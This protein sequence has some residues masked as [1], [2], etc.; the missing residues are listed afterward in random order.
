M[1]A[2]AKY[3]KNIGISAN[4]DAA[5]TLRDINN[6]ICAGGARGRLF[7]KRY[8]ESDSPLYGMLRRAAAEL[9]EL[10]AQMEYKGKGADLK[11]ISALQEMLAQRVNF[12]T[13]NNIYNNQVNILEAAH[14]DLLREA[15]PNQGLETS[16]GIQVTAAGGVGAGVDGGAKAV[17]KLEGSAQYRNVDAIVYDDDL[18]LKVQ[19]SDVWQLKFAAKADADGPIDFR[20][21]GAEAAIAGEV[22]RQL[23]TK[24]DRPR[25]AFTAF[26]SNQREAYVHSSPIHF[27]NHQPDWELIAEEEHKDI[28]RATDWAIPNLGRSAIERLRALPASTVD[29]L[30]VPSRPFNDLQLLK[31]QAGASTHMLHD[32]LGRLKDEALNKYTKHFESNILDQPSRVYRGHHDQVRDVTSARGQVEVKGNIGVF[33]KNVNDGETHK[34]GIGA[35]CKLSGHITRTTRDATL[36]MPPHESIQKLGEHYDGGAGAA[37]ED[38]LNKNRDFRAYAQRSADRANGVSGLAADLSSFRELSCQMQAA[39]A[40]LMNNKSMENPV[41]KG[42]AWKSF[43]DAHGRLQETFLF[44]PSSLPAD[45][46]KEP[47]LVKLCYKQFGK[48]W[49]ALSTGMAAMKHGQSGAGNQADAHELKALAADIKEVGVQGV[50]PL[51][52]YAYSDMLL[53]N[54]SYK[55]WDK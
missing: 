1:D 33:N 24:H 23:Y 43:K 26:V 41:L 34:I 28:N 6:Q 10:S 15:V 38:F 16:Y 8:G 25:D 44:P 45:A 29:G 9:L 47:E 5:T 46:P 53:Q 17:A 36:I 14:G 21:L 40:L 50:H 11:K 52:A 20:L 22:T 12:C 32:L 39:K 4:E 2:V 35:F 18:Q 31:G 13:I 49:T 37:L 48:A 42:L 51:L 27:K 55:A 19:H 7:F 54:I 3:L 30:H